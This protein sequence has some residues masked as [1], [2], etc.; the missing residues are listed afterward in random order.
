MSGDRLD[1]VPNLLQL[2][3][4]LRAKNE[5]LAF[6][7]MQ[8]ASSPWDLYAMVA[9]ALRA[10]RYFAIRANDVRNRADPAHIWTL[11]QEADLVLV[12]LSH[13]NVNV[14]MELGASLAYADAALARNDVPLPLAL[15][16]DSNA[17]E[18]SRL[19][20]DLRGLGITSYE[21]DH[22]R[23]ITEENI[24]QAVH[25]ALDKAP[26]ATGIRSVPPHQVRVALRD[27][28]TPA[29][30]LLAALP[31]EVTTVLADPASSLLV[32]RYIQSLGKRT[33]LELAAS[34][35]FPD[36]PT[37]WWPAPGGPLTGEFASGDDPA[38][39]VPPVLRDEALATV[40]AL[41]DI[42]QTRDSWVAQALDVSRMSEVDRRLT[43]VGALLKRSGDRSSAEV[44][45][46]SSTLSLIESTV[47]AGVSARPE[48]WN[49]GLRAVRQFSRMRAISVAPTVVS[50][51]P[52]IQAAARRHWD[53]LTDYEQARSDLS[54][55][56]KE[57]AAARAR[58][59][60]SSRV[61]H[62]ATL[63]GAYYLGHSIAV[64]RDSSSP[65]AAAALALAESTLPGQTV[66]V[67]G[68][69]NDRRTSD[70]HGKR[71]A[72]ADVRAY[73]D[74]LRNT[75][76]TFA[77]EHPFHLRVVLEVL[78]GENRRYPAECILTQE[79]L[80]YVWRTGFW[81]TFLWSRDQLPLVA[82]FLAP[83][84][85][86]ATQDRAFVQDYVAFGRTPHTSSFMRLDYPA[87]GTEIAQRAWWPEALLER[88]PKTNRVVRARRL[89]NL[90]KTVAEGMTAIERQQQ[91][92]RVW[93]GQPIETDLDDVAGEVLG[94]DPSHASPVWVS[95]LLWDPARWPG[96]TFPDL[97]QAEL[98]A[99]EWLV[100]TLSSWAGDQREAKAVRAQAQT[101][102]EIVSAFARRY[103]AGQDEDGVPGLLKSLER[104]ANSADGRLAQRV[105]DVRARVD[106]LASA[107]E[108]ALDAAAGSP[109]FDLTI[110][111]GPIRAT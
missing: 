1:E 9:R 44:E 58:E 2:K 100:M 111:S 56:Q 84:Q 38:T 86:P 76:P 104:L 69:A 108:R 94:W 41:I 98:S 90:P 62:V 79:A 11:L 31:D 53:I 87:A 60:E 33:E 50:T 34:A 27:Q 30:E 89:M 77:V 91:L 96:L 45:V 64:L 12:D 19:P 15:I 97:V 5:R 18:G 51:I 22:K 66:V 26:D 72:R 92:G 102:L 24:K 29:R 37:A 17:V 78:S 63:G 6:V 71:A 65:S 4:Q 20:F 99:A 106:N 25:D 35:G 103:V 109:E 48:Y 16:A 7:V 32:T 82:N 59:A 28:S 70:S 88:D 13:W 73:V 8:F 49:E 95:K 46:L 14:Y 57:Q 40:E 107:L 3:Q 81:E 75:R 42:Q 101:I 74:G 110:T 10:R 85:K 43:L 52:R 55:R 21:V 61:T 23:A 105:R 93:R 68:A 80:R 47:P 39:P 36:L 67:P 83:R 54:P